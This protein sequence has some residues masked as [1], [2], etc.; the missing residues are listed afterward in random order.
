MGLC[1]VVVNYM[2]FLGL[3][4]LM[5]CGYYYG[6]GFWVDGGL[7]VDWILVY[8][9]WVDCNGIGFDWIVCGSNVVS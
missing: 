8:Y 6:F 5:V 3:Y 2:I 1:E 9:Y 4:Y 7:C